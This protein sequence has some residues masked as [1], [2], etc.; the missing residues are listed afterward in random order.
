MAKVLIVYEPVSQKWLIGKLLETMQARGLQIDAFNLRYQFFHSGKN[1]SGIVKIVAAIPKNRITIFIIRKLLYNAILKTVQKEYDAIDVHYFSDTYVKFLKQYKKPY[2]ITTW[3]SDFYRESKEWLERKRGVYLK[4]K[5]IQV[6]TTTVLKDMNIYEPKLQDKIR[7]CN[8]GVDILEEIDQLKLEGYKERLIKS[9][10]GSFVVTC[11]YNGTAAQ[12]HLMILEQI[13]NLDDDI[14]REI[15]LCIPATYGLT[16]SYESDLKEKL[17]QTGVKYVIIKNR[18]PDIDLAKLR[19]ETDV[20]VN[21]Q[22]SDSLSS[23]LLQ[24]LYAGNVLLLG[25]W[26]PTDTYN[27][28]GIYYQQVSVQTL[29]DKLESVIKDIVKAK[30]QCEGN[31][32]MIG[33]FATWKSVESRQF[34][35][36]QELLT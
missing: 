26:L 36:Y 27:E 16:D 15:Y 8:F 12:Q 29:T 30:K 21:M 32:E 14:K 31:H 1:L 35:I 7:V 28:H 33:A 24:H 4:A 34:D 6:E 17:R 5:N 25:K 23:S 20:V 3:G 10:E 9:P 2:K 18:L 22:I 11:G 13:K 19:V